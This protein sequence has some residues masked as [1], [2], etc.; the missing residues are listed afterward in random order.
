MH[1][2]SPPTCLACFRSARNLRMIAISLSPR[3]RTSP[4]CTTT[5]SPPTHFP[6]S[7]MT[8]ASSSARTA[9]RKSPCKSPTATKRRPLS[10]K[11]VITPLASLW[12]PLGALCF[13]CFD[14]AA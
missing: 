14:G 11:R 5:A 4:T 9:A 7:S 2:T 13:F 3:S 12:S 8:P 10:A 6:D 1:T